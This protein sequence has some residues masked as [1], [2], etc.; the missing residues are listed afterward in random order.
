[1]KKIKLN[2]N[3]E[4]IIG[5]YIL[6]PTEKYVINLAEEMEFQSA[7]MGSFQIMGRPPALKN[8]HAWLFE[9]GFSVD[10]PNPTNEFVAPY[11]GVKPLWETEYSQGIVVKDENDSDYFIVMECS[12]KNKGYKHTQIILTL[13][14][15]M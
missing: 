4:T 10:A 13:G 14:G 15:C 11:Y 6:N 8:Y 9:N 2:Q 5:G 1:M 12:D 7:I 3:S